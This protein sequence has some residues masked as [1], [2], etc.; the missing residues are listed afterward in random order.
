MTELCIRPARDSAELRS[1]APDWSDRVDDHDLSVSDRSVA[2]MI[3][4][5]GV[6]LI[7]YRPVRDLQRSA[8][9]SG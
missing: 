9:L 7:G 5:A 4:R 3:Q 6:V 1:L 2:A 8:A